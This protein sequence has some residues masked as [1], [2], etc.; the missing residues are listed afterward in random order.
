MKSIDV[1]LNAPILHKNAKRNFVRHP[2]K[3]SNILN[4]SLIKLLFEM[5]FELELKFGI[6]TLL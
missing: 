5:L 3:L 1:T 4:R 6:F 2:A